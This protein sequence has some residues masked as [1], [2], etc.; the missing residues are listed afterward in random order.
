MS[1]EINIEENEAK[2]KR[3][4][5]LFAAGFLVLNGVIGAGIFG[6]PGKLVEQAGM[7]GP[8]LII[9]F[10]AF[11]I[12]VAWTFASIASYFNTTGGPV[13]YA[14]RAFGPLIGFQTGWLLYIGRVSA[15]AANINVLFNY[16]AFLWDGASGELTRGVMFFIIIGGLT[17]I[18]VMGVKKTVKALN[19]ITLIKILPVFLLILLSIPHLT[20]EGILPG[21]LPS[22]DD[23]S[24]LVLLILYA[25]V[26]FEG[27]LVTAGETKDP[28]KTIPRALISG[29]LV[30]TAIYFAIS[31]TYANVV[32][33]GGGDTPL[34]DMADI[35]IGPVGVTMIIIAA[36]FSI[37]GNATAIV[38]A[39]PRMTFAMAEEG[40]LPGWFG[41]VHE[42]YHTPANSIIFLGVL[43]FFLAISGTFVYLAIAST[44]ARMIAYAICMVSLPNIRKKADAETLENAT[45]LPGGYI[46]PGIAFVVC[47]FA[48]SQSTQQSWM[49][50]AG[51]V[52]LGSAL[53]FANRLLSKNN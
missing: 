26:G 17:A 7:F 14:N 48:I 12:T 6:L 20:P 43:S 42:E 28:K 53:Y 45:K 35:L 50:M 21:N 18:N 10:G 9:I 30:I 41:K 49:Y 25:F 23:M 37:L 36:I 4:I 40:T 46:I 11:I 31:L 24:G 1:N 44:L 32:Q 27:A 47:L 39:A 2:L 52:V 38:V 29:V 3:D 15:I 16:V 19:V 8:W 5:G 13:A 51:F 34:I 22:F 33:D